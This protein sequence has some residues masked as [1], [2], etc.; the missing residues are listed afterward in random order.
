MPGVSPV[1]G[2]NRTALDD[3]FGSVEVGGLLVFLAIAGALNSSSIASHWVVSLFLL[4]C[5]ALC[6]GFLIPLSSR[7]PSLGF[8]VSAAVL[9]FTAPQENI[10]EAIVVWAIGTLIGSTAVRRSVVS[11][12]RNASRMVWCGAA[13]MVIWGAIDPDGDNV[14]LAATVATL[15]YII[16]G[17]LLDLFSR[18]L[19]GEPVRELLRS[20]MMFRL[21]LAYLINVL[22]A[23]LVHLV[24]PPLNAAAETVGE[25][26]G[27]LIAFTVT[28]MF[29]F[30]FAMLTNAAIEH[31]RFQGV[32]ASALALPW[33]GD[34][35][36]TELM[37]HYASRAIPSDLIEIRDRQPRRLR[38]LGA[39]FRM[40]SGERR[41]LVVERGPTRSAYAPGDFDALSAIAHIGEESMRVRSETQD[42]ELE[43]NTDP[44]TGLPNYRAFQVALAQA[45][46]G[47]PTGMG[48]AVVYVDMDG[49][50]AINDT[51]GHEVGN[52]VLRMV[53]TRLRGA[54]RPLDT[55]AR[56]GGDEFV[57][58]LP[59][60]ID[61]EHAEQIAS[62]IATMVSPPLQL[63]DAVIIPSISTGV[64]FSAEPG[65]D[66]TSLV[67][68]ADERMYSG[69][70]RRDGSPVPA[71]AE[72]TVSE[73]DTMPHADLVDV[74]ADT[75]ERRLVT[76]A[77]QPIVDL[78]EGRIVA[79][80]ALVRATHPD[81]GMISPP[82]L[83]HEARRMQR[84]DELT[85]QVLVQAF[86]DVTSFQQV[87]PE[88]DVVHVNIEVDQ[89]AEE[90]SLGRIA[91][92]S[93][94]YQNVRLTLELTE[95]SLNRSTEVL[96]T[97]LAG[98][99]ARGISLSLDDF[100]QAYSTML[101]L[102]E[103]PFDVLKVDRVLIRD[104]LTSAKS[105]HIIRSLVL[106]ARKL[107]VRMVVE[108][109]ETDEEL[110][111]LA[112]LG[113]RY[114]QGYIFAR[115]TA[116]SQLRDRFAV[117]GLQVAPPSAIEPTV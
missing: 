33:P 39:P 97:E 71:L 116:P 83:V 40:P 25:D 52:Q 81:Y 57:I 30:S 113:V 27:L 75:I 106:L 45:N 19:Q 112:L 70:G 8:G 94:L 44:L 88:L 64:A 31:R 16:V 54:V 102:V 41:W 29:F 18:R 36:P 1:R 79:L 63:T 87:V 96:M 108:G 93:D 92:L 73:P 110:E 24:V 55:V 105:R 6:S 43:A 117:T 21:L 12:A 114:V 32:L 98:L 74:I 58:I 91:E 5:A 3:L 38:E 28:A 69:R 101:A 53:S 109:V 60:V 100:G 90:R 107:D 111:A 61:R 67:E 42:L 66:I 13:Y 72:P 82:L 78:V 11:G 103:Y 115:P 17:L 15:G 99:R 56:V 76:V 37:R 23:T 47:R 50:K 86:R 65:E 104:L 35:D 2:Q 89:V 7:D 95:N 9:G 85:E 14:A 77:Y 34:Q 59:D 26:V 48:L 51:Y 80:E 68:E 10:L 84:L 62:R 46:V 49:F 20:I 22:M 4:L